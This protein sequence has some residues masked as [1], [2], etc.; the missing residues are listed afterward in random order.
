MGRLLFILL[1]LIGGGAARADLPLQGTD[2]PVLSFNLMV[3]HDNHPGMP[4]LNLMKSSRAFFGRLPGKWGGVSHE[5]L[6]AGG[7]LD[8]DG[9]PRRIPPGV[10]KIGTVF[11]WG[12]DPEMAS[13]RRGR[14][15][16]RYK[17][18]GRVT[19]GGDAHTLS[20]RP[21][22]VL[23]EHRNGG[24]W[25]LDI[26]QTDPRG[27][28]D[29]VRDI[30]V[31]PER[32]F[33]L[34]Q[35]GAVFNPDWVALIAD[36]RELRFMDWLKTNNSTLSR[37]ADRP[38]AE[39]PHEDR[40]QV[41]EDMI[42]L[43]NEVGAD[44]WFTMPHLADADYIRRFARLVH[45]TLD[46]R[47]VVRVEWS[48]EVWNNMFQQTRWAR[49]ASKTAWGEEAH[50]DYTA[51]KAVEMALIWREVFRDAPHRLKTVLGGRTVSTWHNRK[52]LE[53]ELWRKYEPD[54]YVPPHE[55]FD[56]LAV[57]SYFA[58]AM[59]MEPE[60]RATVLRAIN[61]PDIDLND[62]LHRRMSDPDNRTSVGRI[63][64]LLAEQKALANAY[65]LTLELYEGGQH[66]H[67]FL[68]PR[69]EDG[70]VTPPEDME[71][72][73]QALIAYVRSPQMAQL[74]RQMWQV[75]EEIGQGAF[76]QYAD[77]SQPGQYGSWGLYAYLGDSTPRSRVLNDLAARTQPWWAG[78]TRGAHYQH[79]IT[80][81][82]TAGSD[83]L[84]GTAEE[85]YLLGGRGDD[86]FDGTAGAD[87]L[88]GGAGTDRVHYA[89]AAAAYQVRA[90]RDGFRV[91]G[92]QSSDFLIH[93]EEISFADGQVRALADLAR[94][95]ATARGTTSGEDR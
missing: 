57:T 48:N 51:K 94:Q 9:W 18:T 54:A 47:L 46:P 93:I 31:V 22:Q 19:V 29:Y 21:G 87:G 91:T 50:I 14:Y 69:L 11:V 89:G 3:A 85:D 83:H 15:I 84:I 73:H 79:G 26:E 8:K 67:Y 68:R 82:G 1:F 75:W 13:Y 62:Y 80:Q 34:F 33:A 32:Y 88:N 77:V 25:W 53:A 60:G 41:L 20:N 44:P 86:L 23:F 6:R 40:G 92:P 39:G 10:E 64:T 72:L 2:N 35:A 66:L 90:E 7:H 45:D 38:S 61:T 37:W 27:T 12:S 56:V 78:A 16:V 81:S 76:M 24:N 52:L 70:S 5:E 43:A 65:D 58:D 55:V 63:A 49:E 17:G 42:R 59:V 74:Y 71:K 36:A 28:G 4:F 30:T 95:P